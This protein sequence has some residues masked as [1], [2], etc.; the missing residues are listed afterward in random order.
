MISESMSTCTFILRPG[1]EGKKGDHKAD[2]DFLFRNLAA[3]NP[4]PRSTG[5]IK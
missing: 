4:S 5:C 1:D 2:I 3:R